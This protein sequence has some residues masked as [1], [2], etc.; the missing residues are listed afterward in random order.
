MRLCIA[1]SSPCPIGT[2]RR[3]ESFDHVECGSER[4]ALSTSR[5]VQSDSNWLPAP[6]GP[7]ILL[8]R[9]YLPEASVLDGRYAYPPVE[10]VSG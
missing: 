2:R 6:A 1:G 8:M 4:S 9:L 10:I 5:R 3:N 7:F